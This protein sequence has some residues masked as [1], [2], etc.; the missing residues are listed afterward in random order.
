MTNSLSGKIALISG[1]G[2]GIGQACALSLAEHGARIAILD[3]DQEA[4]L[5][6]CQQ[7]EAAGGQAKHFSVE[8]TSPK[9]LTSATLEI[10]ETFG[11]IDVLIN[12]ASLSGIE[13]NLIDFDFENW[14]HVIAVN[15]EAPRLLISLVGRHMSEKGGGKIV[16]ISS[17]SGSRA[18]GR[19]PSY[20]IS[21]AALNAL[22]RAAAAE[23]GKYNINVN[24]VAPG[25]TQTP[26]QHGLRNEDEMAEAVR[27]GPLANFFH[28]VSEPQ[29]V[30][31]TV[32]F[33]C[34]PSSRQITGQVIHT[35]AGVIV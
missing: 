8:M 17:S 6:T 35:S 26:L 23:L 32:T 2:R 24:A 9:S 12:A 31:A 14:R 28:R 21:K 4:A 25:I 10:I 34:L 16:S 27:T 5:G 19:R 30:A 1:A 22:T 29:D 13:D 18:P 20:G 15:L 3:H 33:L 7:I 11:G